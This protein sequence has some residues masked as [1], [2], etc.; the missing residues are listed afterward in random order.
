MKEKKSRKEDPDEIR[1]KIKSRFFKSLKICINK[2]LDRKGIN[3][4][5][6]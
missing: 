3:K 5:F 2:E 4:K 1:K 6:E